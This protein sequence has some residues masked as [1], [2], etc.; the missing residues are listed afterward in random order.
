MM[1]FARAARSW[2]ALVLPALVAGCSAAEPDVPEDPLADVVYVPW[3]GSPDGG[4]FLE[5]TEVTNDAF[6]KFLKASTYRDDDSGFLLHWK[7]PQVGGPVPPPGFESHPVVHVSLVD[8]EAY[9]RWKKMRIP[10]STEWEVA[11]GYG[12][13]GGYPFGLFQP[14]RANTLELGLQHTTPVGLFENGRSILGM[15]DLAGNVSELA[16][17][18]NGP[19]PKGG[20][21]KQFLRRVDTNEIEAPVAPT[22]SAMD[23]GFRCAADAIGLLMERVVAGSMSNDTKIRSFVG[24]LKRSGAP[25]RRL[26]EDLAAKHSSARPLVNAAIQQIGH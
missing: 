21:F 18:P 13:D 5:L 24:F 12:V 23:V 17:G 4:F 11:A 16:I 25:G 26:L 19:I 15:Y 7:R 20:S 14:L 9:A 8:A 10:T 22:F 3:D 6:A 1:A 2:A